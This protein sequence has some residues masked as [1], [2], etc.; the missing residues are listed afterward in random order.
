MAM[1][2]AKLDAVTKRRQ[3]DDI[4]TTLLISAYGE[5]LAEYPADVVRY[6]LNETPNQCLFF[7][8]WAELYEDLE[9]WGR[10]RLLLRGKVSANISECNKGD[11]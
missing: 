9:F 3:E 6:V 1:E 10:D 7:P 8:A 5:K 2:L 4:D 11:G